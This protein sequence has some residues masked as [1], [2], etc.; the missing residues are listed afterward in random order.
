MDLVSTCVKDNIFYINLSG[1]IDSSNAPVLESEILDAV[2]DRNIKTVTFGK[3]AGNNFVASDIRLNELGQPTYKLIIDGEDKGEVTLSVTGEHN[4]VNSLAA[5]AA[6]LYIGID[7]D[8]IK[9][10]LRLCHSAD[11]RFQY[12]GTM[13]NGAVIVDDYG[14]V[15][16]TGDTGQHML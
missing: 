7:L 3:N 10:G 1:R 4:A 2:K 16:D 15:V 13:E 11:R 9:E 8:N 5:I 14:T 12:K 6:S